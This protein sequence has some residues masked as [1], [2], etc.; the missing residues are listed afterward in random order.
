MT[1]ARA[2]GAAV[3]ASTMAVSFA[4]ARET[5]PRAAASRGADGAPTVPNPSSGTARAD[6]SIP[7]KPDLD[8]SPGVIHQAVKDS[9]DP[10]D[11]IA[12]ARAKVAFGTAPL[13][14]QQRI[15]RAF[16]DAQI[17]TCM[18]MDAWKFAPPMLGPIPIPGIFAAPFLVRNIVTGKCRN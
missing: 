2:W 6:A 7:K 8:L 3:V 14:R 18:T 15:D 16:A 13:T 9:I 1:S 5:E 4:C 10:A 12:D 11:E 17:P